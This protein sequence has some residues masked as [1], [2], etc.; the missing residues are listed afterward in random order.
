[1]VKQQLEDI[2]SRLNPTTD[3]QKWVLKLIKVN[4]VD[5]C[6]SEVVFYLNDAF[7]HNL[8][9]ADLEADAMDRKIEDRVHEK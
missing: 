7:G 6:Y 1:M 4:M 9:L 5:K 2:I 3:Y 8:S